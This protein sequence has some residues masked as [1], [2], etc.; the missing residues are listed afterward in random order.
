MRHPPSIKNYRQPRT[1]VFLRKEHTNWLTHSKLSALEACIQK[2]ILLTK[3]IV[4]MIL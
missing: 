1:I 3:Q 4:F 2:N